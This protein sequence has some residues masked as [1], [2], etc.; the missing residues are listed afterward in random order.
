VR[1]ALNQLRGPRGES[2][3]TSRKMI[4]VEPKYEYTAAVPWSCPLVVSPNDR[5]AKLKRIVSR[6]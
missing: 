5:H 2:K 3:R 6:P 4:A 1:W